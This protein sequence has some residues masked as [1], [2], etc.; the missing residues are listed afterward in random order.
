MN[1]SL[2]NLLVT[3][4]DEKVH[5]YSYSLYQEAKLLGDIAS[6]ECFQIREPGKVTIWKA[7]R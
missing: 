6:N 4:L 3:D 2:K 1:I 5:S 7:Q